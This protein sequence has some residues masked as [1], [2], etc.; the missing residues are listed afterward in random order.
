[1]TIRKANKNNISNELIVLVVYLCVGVG[2]ASASNDDGLNVARQL[3]DASFKC[4]VTIKANGNTKNWHKFTY[5]GT[6]SK[7]DVSINGLDSSS[8]EGSYS[9]NE[10]EY[11]TFLPLLTI[12]HHGSM[13]RLQ[14]K[15][16]SCLFHRWVDTGCDDG[17]CAN[18]GNSSLRSK[19]ISD[20]EFEMCDGDAAADAADALTELGR[21][22]KLAR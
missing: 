19:Y 21:R 1:M 11:A 10:G 5:K 13:L 16:P 2:S 18:A 9:E 15:K 6:D 3:V 22:A 17:I 14:C 12:S 7:F 8:P 4:P 20:V